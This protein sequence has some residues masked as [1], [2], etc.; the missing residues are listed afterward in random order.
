MSAAVVGL[1]IFPVASCAAAQAVEGFSVTPLLNDVDIAPGTQVTRTLTVTSAIAGRTTFTVGVED[2]AGSTDAGEGIVLLGEEVESSISGYDWLKPNVGSFTLRPGESR[3]VTIVI[4]APAGAT[5]GH[6]AAVTIAAEAEQV[7]S[8]NVTAQSRAAS[9]FLMNAGNTSPPPVIISEVTEQI[10]GDTIIT[11]EDG[12]STDVQPD[13]EIT[14]V[15]PITGQVHRVSKSAITCTRALPGGK[16]Q[17]T[18]SGSD[19]VNRG[20]GLLSRGIVTLTNDGR[21][22]TA[23]LPIR[24]TGTWKSAVL[25]AI[26]IAVLILFFWR[27]RRRNIEILEHDLELI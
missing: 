27:R 11:Y 9:V 4:N 20:S 18:I 1:L 16:G 14:Y 26:G 17:C 6:Y 25:P 19:L 12:G 13:A 5:G 3:T 8:G 21:S 2:V 10:G 15:D 22:V 23:K 7:G 24:W